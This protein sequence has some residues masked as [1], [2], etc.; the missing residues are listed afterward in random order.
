MLPDSHYDK[1]KADRAVKFIE[2]LP[3]TKGEWEGRPF[4]LLPWQEQIIRDLFGIVKAD[5]FRQFRT[6]YIE[7]PKK[8]GKSELAAAIALYLLYADHEPS[9]EVFSAAADRQQASIVFDVAKRMVEMTPG[10][11]K[12]SKVMSATKRI[13]NYSNAGYYQVVSADVGGKHGY[14]IS[15]LVFDEIHNQ[16]NRKLWDVLTKGSGDARRQALHVAITTAGTDR[17][18]ICFELHTKALDILSDRKVDP[19]FYPVVYSL[20]MDADWQDEKNWYK[21]NPSLG[22]T[23]PIERMREAYLQSQDNPAEENVFRTLRLCQWVG[24]T[25]QWIPD[26]IYDLGNQPID[27]H[28][29]R[30]RDCYAGLDLS[31]SGDITALV[32]MF[33]P[34]TDD[35]KYIML[36]YFWVPEETIP[37]RVQQTSVPYDN[38]VAQ[39]YVKATP[40]NVIDY[41]YIQNTIGELSYKYHIRE[42]AFDRWGSNM[43]VERLSEMGLTVVPFGQ[44][45]KD[46]SPASRAFYEELMKGNI[47]HGGNPVMKWMCGNVVIEQDPAGNIKPTKAKS[48]DK[49]NSSGKEIIVHARKYQLTHLLE[50][51]HAKR[52]GGRVAARVHIKPVEEKVSEQLENDI[53]RKISNGSG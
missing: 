37:K 42:I 34:R 19:T 50:N 38:W 31:S 6:A 11:Q 51:G 8:Q 21:V 49:D 14:S 25:V 35:E 48:K 24:S 29:L 10:L 3:H 1:K 44:G 47:I 43:L 40:G 45:Y 33:P 36:P 9:A 53:K 13:V 7:I 27:K 16:P 30:R 20:P 23:V 12:R 26:H 5:G 46:M 4:W 39:G 18:S 32:L 15:G 41:A 28:A 2:M 22:Y 52:G 17:N